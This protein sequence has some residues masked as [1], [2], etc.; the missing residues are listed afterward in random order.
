MSEDYGFKISKPGQNVLTAA[1]AQ[2]N[3]SSKFNI[4]KVIKE[5]TTTVNWNG[6]THVGAVTQVAHGM[7]FTPTFLAFIEA[8][9]NKWM[10]QGG[11]STQVSDVDYVSLAAYADSSNINL[12]MNASIFSSR[13]NTNLNLNVKYFI[14]GDTAKEANT[15]TAMPAPKDYGLKIMKTG[16]NI[17]SDFIEDMLF[18]S[19]APSMMISTQSSTSI[20]SGGVTTIAHGLGYKPAYLVMVSPNNTTFYLSYFNPNVAGPQAYGW[21][22]GTN[23]NLRSFNGVGQTHYFRYIIFV[24]KLN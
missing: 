20:T 5:G 7:N 18:N 22:D 17:T 6:T 1:D 15:T 12:N 13:R 2:M 21:V 8:D 14:F 11:D 16:K 23:L 3:Y 24:N 4:L 10:G 9:T 19:E